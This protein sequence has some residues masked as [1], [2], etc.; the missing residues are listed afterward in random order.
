MDTERRSSITPD[1]FHSIISTSID[2]FLLVDLN[3]SFMETNDSYCQMVGYTRNELLNLHVSSI[4]AIDTSDDV[5]R[6]FETI[7]KKG[8]LR[9]ETRHRHK[10]GTIIAV[11]V[12]ANY[13]P[14]HGGSIFSF[15][16]DVSE[17]KHTR[18]IMAARLRLLEYSLNHSLQE[19]LRTTL[20]EAEALTG[21]CI[22]FYHFNDSDRQILT[23]QA[24]STKTATMFCTAEGTGSHY[25]ISQAGVWTDCVHEKRTVIHNDYASLP[26]R[27][28]LPEG[29][30]TVIR[31]MVVPIFRNDKIV[32]IVGIG[33]K[34]TDYN[35]QDVEVITRLADL[36]WDIV[37]RK[38]AEEALVHEKTF[39]RSL[40]DAADDLI[41]FKD[42][43]GVY[44]ACNKASENFIGLSESEQ[45]GKSDYDLLAHETAEIVAKHD[46]MV[47]EDGRVLRTAEKVFHPTMGTVIM[48]TVKAPIYGPDGQPLGLVG[49]SRDI[50]ERTRVE[51]A[52]KE[53]EWKFQALFDNGPIGVAYHR[54]IYDESG[55][56]VDYSFVDANDKYIELTGVDPRG[57]TVLQ[58]FPGIENDPFDWIGTFGAV[59]RTGKTVRFEQYLQSNDRWYDVVGYRYKPDHFVAA[60][61]EI[62]EQKRAEIA[63]QN[64]HKLLQTII[65]TAPVR[66]FWKD[67]EM[68]YLGCNSAFAKDAG[69]VCPDELIGR[70]DFQLSWKDRAEQYRADDRLVMESGIAKLSYDEQQTT[71]NGT[72]MWLRTSKAPLR[73]EADKIFAVLGIYEDVTERKQAETALIKS[74]Q[75]FRAIIDASPVPLA[76]N[77]DYGIITFLNN[78]FV[79]T[80]GY[81][82]KDIPTLEK[83]WLCAYPDT[84]YR[85]TVTGTWVR[86]LEESR[87]TGAPFVPL[88][89]NI[90]CKDGSVRTFICTATSIES[91]I[92]GSHLV[93]LFDIT[94][95]KRLEEEKQ[96]LEQQFQQAQKLES[97]GVLAGGIAHDFNNILA[98]IIGHCSL[99]AL[100]PNAAEK[101]IPAIEKAADRA[102]GLCRQM[103]AYAGKASFTLMQ[104]NMAAL[105]DEMVQM[106]KATT[107]RNVA[108]RADLS[109]DIPFVKGDASQLRQIVM[110]LIINASEA[111][112]EAQGVIRITLAKRAVTT[113]GA[114]RDHLGRIIPAGWYACLEISDTGCGMDD[115]AMCRIFEPFFTTKFTGRGLGM[116]A[117]LGIISAHGGALQLNSQPGHGTT[118]TIYLPI[119]NNSS[120]GDEFSDQINSAQWQG[121]GTV[122]LVEDEDQVR[123]V[124]RSMLEELGFT[125]VET[126]NGR[127]ALDVFRKYVPEISLVVTDIGMPFMDGYTLFRELKILKPEL[128]IVISSGFGDTVVTTRIRAEEVAGLVSKPYRF[129]QLR[130]VLRSVTDGT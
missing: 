112:G 123:F 87:R 4:D 85:Q 41:Y 81:T 8:S 105:V 111:I 36:S 121:S 6:R 25:P 58:A 12:S 106:L 19:L 50:T 29:H 62:T 128:P 74:E 86:H 99:A 46:R 13:S 120:V 93:V 84:H 47:I 69:V 108:I 55:N 51:E 45:I 43:N 27:K 54:M 104:V 127:E 91:G 96:L 68:R 30:A 78:A 124:A 115:E 9:F 76:I 44:L 102:A 49:I 21:S 52:L 109:A 15:I 117:V 64:T 66:V 11:E 61:F 60:F 35:Q 24:W 80:V 83:W 119:E 34:P 126:S 28:G 3:G 73:N 20:D 116:S 95:R 75:N 70:D 37:E 53:S 89:V 129:D 59:A 1:D 26:H 72:T 7:I 94:D 57:K 42:R 71:P 22:G 79:Q 92:D 48:D 130:D 103:L 18:E 33:N 67:T 77:N 113:A 2:G 39:L 122:L 10:D 88:E 5:A 16:R 82:T 114:V 90:A 32:A 38:R 14:G 107:S 110:N 100:N 23:L 31:E 98:I 101:H 118:F 56:S 97:L 40:I 125:V 65:N 63:T 17:Q